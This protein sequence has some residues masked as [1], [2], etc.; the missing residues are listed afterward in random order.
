M[1]LLSIQAHRCFPRFH[2]R[3]HL[4]LLA[5]VS[6]FGVIRTA[7][8]LHA[9][10][11]QL[12]D[13]LHRIFATKELEEQSFG[14]ARWLEDGKAYTTLEPSTPTA[15]TRDILRYD[16]ASGKREVLVSASRLVPAGS[17]KPPRAGVGAAARP[18]RWP[19]AR[20]ASAT[21]SAR[22]SAGAAGW[23]AAAGADVCEIF[24]RRLASRVCQ[25]E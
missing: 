18:S 2:A 14:P 3:R 9:Q 20:R 21:A 7:P 22:G 8:G 4:C 12:L 13:S 24:S 5:A 25:S 23:G 19:R 16:T 6:A 15:E 17:K 11:P 10:T 1:T